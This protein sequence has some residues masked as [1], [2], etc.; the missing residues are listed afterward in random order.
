[1]FVGGKPPA[2]ASVIITDTILVT[3]PVYATICSLAAIG[4]VIAV[5][6]LILNVLYRKER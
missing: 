3:V 1:M 2:D 5:V 6:C 4:I